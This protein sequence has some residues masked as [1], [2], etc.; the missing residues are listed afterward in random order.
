M[1][2]RS[3]LQMM[4]NIEIKRTLNRIKNLKNESCQV[5]ERGFTDYIFCEVIQKLK[6]RPDFIIATNNNSI[7][8]GYEYNANSL[9][10]E[11]E[12]SQDNC[13]KVTIIFNELFGY[14]TDNLVIATIKPKISWINE[15]DIK[16]I[17][18]ISDIINKLKNNNARD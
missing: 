18:N 9:R 1:K 7:L 5:F 6:N 10:L 16:E 13:A 11:I 14:K 17:D 2:K 15:N 3:S 12:I 4:T 8:L